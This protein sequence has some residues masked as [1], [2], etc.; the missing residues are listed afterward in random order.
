MPVPFAGVVR[1]VV[2]EGTKARQLALPKQSSGVD[3]SR[4]QDVRALDNDSAVDDLRLRPVPVPGKN[5][6]VRRTAE[7]QDAERGFHQIIA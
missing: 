3:V 4:S 5:R 1:G 7:P 6:V 2:V